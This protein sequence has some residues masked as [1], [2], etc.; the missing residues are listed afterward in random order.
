MN[1]CDIYYLCLNISIRYSL[2]HRVL[3]H[4]AWAKGNS[5]PYSNCS[6]FLSPSCSSLVSHSPTLFRAFPQV[7]ERNYIDW[8]EC[9]CREWHGYVSPN[10]LILWGYSWIVTSDGGGGRS[11]TA[12]HNESSYC[13][14]AGKGETTVEK[15][16]SHFSSQQGGD[17]NYSSGKIDNIQQIDKLVDKGRAITKIDKLNESNVFTNTFMVSALKGM[18]VPTLKVCVEP[19]WYNFDGETR[20]IWQNNRCHGHG[21]FPR[22]WYFYSIHISFHVLIRVMCSM[23]LSQ[24]WKG[25]K[26][27]SERVSITAW[28][29]N[30]HT[31]SHKK[32]WDGT[33]RVQGK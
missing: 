13:G 3:F 22:T 28:I 4:R 24:R 21:N 14:S 8:V 32:I 5:L 30:F 2:T 11:E 29:R 15:Q 1:I 20:I 25:L 23:V 16:T 26:R 27:L 19:C 17:Q 33:R 7:R 10:V 31:R 9:V 18:N 12:G 6:S